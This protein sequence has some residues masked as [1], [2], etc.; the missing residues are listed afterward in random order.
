MPYCHLPSWYDFKND[1]LV[2]IRYICGTVYSQEKSGLIGVGPQA[3]IVCRLGS[4]IVI[5]FDYIV[6]I[7]LTFGSDFGICQNSQTLRSSALDKVGKHNFSRQARDCIPCIRLNPREGS[8]GKLIGTGILMKV[9][10]EGQDAPGRSN[11]RL[12]VIGKSLFV[13]CG[14]A[15][16]PGNN[17]RREYA[18]STSPTEINKLFPAGSGFRRGRHGRLNEL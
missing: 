5:Y 3:Y 2:K 11:N 1:S 18:F 8:S 6:I 4:E 9:A 14:I 13:Q 16:T 7:L 17:R 15:G 12:I 10:Y